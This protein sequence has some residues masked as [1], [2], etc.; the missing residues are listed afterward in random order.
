MRCCLSGYEDWAKKVSAQLLTGTRRFMQWSGSTD[1]WHALS[2]LEFVG[3]ICFLVRKTEKV[4]SRAS[5]G[6][7]GANENEVA[8]GLN[9]ALR[10]VAGPSVL[11]FKSMAARLPTQ[12]GGKTII[13]AKWWDAQR[14]LANEEVWNYD[15]INGLASQ[16]ILPIRWG[17][18]LSCIQSKL[19]FI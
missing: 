1:S 19:C 12:V 16:V 7:V 18:A 11:L 13:S 3:Q 2:Y 6:E 17:A 4:K 8:R 5:G 14:R 9:W 10:K 15:Q